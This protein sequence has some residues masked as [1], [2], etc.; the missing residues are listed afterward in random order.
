MQVKHNGAHKHMS[1]V[2]EIIHENKITKKTLIIQKNK[3]TKTSHE[4]GQ[5]KVS[6]H[7]I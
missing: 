5:N 3:Q 2:H 1:R 7:T 4:Q 6:K